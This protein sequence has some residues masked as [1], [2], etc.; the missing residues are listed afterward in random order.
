MLRDEQAKFKLDNI[1]LICSWH[2]I[3]KARLKKGGPLL[4][5]FCKYL[6]LDTN[7]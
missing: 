1:G 2:E 6:L 4:F 7:S 5:I 3:K